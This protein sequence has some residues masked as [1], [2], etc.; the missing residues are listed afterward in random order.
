MKTL[1]LAALALALVV[2]CSV[3]APAPAGAP[4][5]PGAKS[6]LGWIDDD[7]TRALAE[8]RARKLPIFI[9]SWAPW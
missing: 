7:Y 6:A 2:A 4:G 8:A 3:P 5:A 1:P 9:E